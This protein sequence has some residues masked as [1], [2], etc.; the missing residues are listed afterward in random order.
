MMNLKEFNKL[1]INSLKPTQI[2]VILMILRLQII[3][4]IN[5]PE[6]IKTKI[7]SKINLIHKKRIKIS[8]KI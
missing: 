3:I 8:S 4:K 2:I 1:I 5:K 7:K 6:S